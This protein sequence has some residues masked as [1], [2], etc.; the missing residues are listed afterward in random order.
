[1]ATTPI[2]YPTVNGVRHDFT[3]IRVKPNGNEVIG[4]K[5]I[6]YSRERSRTKVWGRHPDPLGKTRGTNDYECEIEVYLAEFNA[7]M[8]DELGGEGYGDVSFPIYVSYDETGSGFDL[9]TDEI[10]GNTLDSTDASNSQGSDPTVRKFKTNPTKIKFGKDDDLAE[11][12]VA[13]PG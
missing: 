5:S 12:L 10:L 2:A 11:P 6:N 9:I 13:P 7:F 3:S 1:M 4:I 8:K